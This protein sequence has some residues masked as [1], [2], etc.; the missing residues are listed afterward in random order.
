MTVKVDK[1]FNIQKDKYMGLLQTAFVVCYM[2]FAPVF[3]YLGDRYSRKWILGIG[4]SKI[5]E[6]AFIKHNFNDTKGGI[7]VHIYLMNIVFLIFL[8]RLHI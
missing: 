5:F 7:E 3:G 8:F 4:I 1:D 6:L 2:L